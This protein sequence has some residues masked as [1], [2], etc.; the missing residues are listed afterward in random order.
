MAKFMSIYLLLTLGALSYAQ[1]Q[2]QDL[3]VK[4][5][6]ENNKAVL[7]RSLETL[8]GDTA[9]WVGNFGAAGIKLAALPSSANPWNSWS[10]HRFIS[11]PSPNEV[12]NAIAAAKQ[13][14]ANVLI[15]QQQMQAAKENVLQQQRLAMEKEAAAAILTQKSE[16]AAAIQRS[17]AAAAAQA[18]VLAQ[19]RLAAAKATVSHQQRIAASREAEAASALQRSAHAAAAEI[20]KTELEASKLGQLARNHNAG[21]AHHLTLAKDSA[22]SSINAGTNHVSLESLAHWPGSASGANGKPASSG[23]L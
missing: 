5:H 10:S 20:Q 1:A 18:V 19:Q 4:D 12:A 22:L 14:S 16:A 6:E 9:P 15:A 23:W 7:K 2:T 13:A 8:V 3:N 17:E 11:G 21:A